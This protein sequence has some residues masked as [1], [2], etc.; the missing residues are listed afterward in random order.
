MVQERAAE[1][2]K[3][4]TFRGRSSAIAEE[5]MRLGKPGHASADSGRVRS[6]VTAGTVVGA[7]ARH[8]DVLAIS[9]QEHERYSRGM[10]RGV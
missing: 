8:F 5:G 9:L 10:G 1:V 4:H 7:V 2:E 6:G 3:A